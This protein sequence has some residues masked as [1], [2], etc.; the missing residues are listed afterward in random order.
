MGYNFKKINGGNLDKIQDLEGGFSLTRLFTG[1]LF[2][3]DYVADFKTQKAWDVWFDKIKKRHINLFVFSKKDPK[4][5]PDKKLEKRGID[6]YSDFLIPPL[7]KEYN[8]SDI[9]N[10]LKDYYNFENG[11][12]NTYKGDNIGRQFREENIQIK[13]RWLTS[14]RVQTVIQYLLNYLNKRIK[15]KKG[16]KEEYEGGIRMI[17]QSLEEPPFKTFKTKIKFGRF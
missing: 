7:L 9:I 4:Y 14:G 16:D 17:R 13:D 2:N 5:K 8:F 12:W 10:I 15:A 11:N 3:D 6:P 1:N